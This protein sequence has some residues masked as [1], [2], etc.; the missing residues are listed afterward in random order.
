MAWLVTQRAQAEENGLFTFDLGPMIDN[1]PAT[2]APPPTRIDLP[3]GAYAWRDAD[4][5]LLIPLEPGSTGMRLLE[6]DLRD[7][8]TRDRTPSSE[9]F[10][11]DSGDWTVSPDGRHVAF[12][13]AGDRNIWLI[14]LD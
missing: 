7:G 5:L 6:H 3:F 2:T 14:A 8:E 13:S 11:I 12:V 4:R 1:G 9:P 10:V